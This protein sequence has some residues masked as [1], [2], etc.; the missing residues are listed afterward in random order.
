MTDDADKPDW[1]RR[2]RRLELE[3]RLE[4]AEQAIRDGIPHLY[5]AHATA[6]L[7]RD[8][9]VRQMKLGDAEGAVESFR[10]SRDFIFFMASLATSGG[11]GAA[12][13]GERDRFMAELIS[14]HGSDPG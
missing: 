8:R 4:E 7:Y 13:S 3:N 9:M 14:L 5:F 10:K 11:E 12:L 1:W 6:D 2:A